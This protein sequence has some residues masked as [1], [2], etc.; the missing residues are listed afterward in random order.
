MKPGEP[1]KIPLTI[2][3]V[4]RPLFE[5]AKISGVNQSTI[6]TRL[7]EL[8]WPAKRAVFEPAK[9]GRP[10]SSDHPWKRSYKGE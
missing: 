6:Y 5:W 9:V 2:D 7:R 8:K 3:G 4:T 1:I 10:R